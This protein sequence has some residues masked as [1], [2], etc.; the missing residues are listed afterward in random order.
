M[1][2]FRADTHVHVYN[3]Y[4]LTQFCNF[5]FENLNVS[6]HLTGILFLTLGS[7]EDRDWETIAARFR[8]L[9]FQVS[10]HS[11][12][13]SIFRHST[14]GA[15]LIVSGFQIITAEKIEVLSLAT[16]EI[17]PDGLPISETIER[18][19]KAGGKVVLPWSPGKWLGKRGKIVNSLLHAEPRGEILF[20]SLKGPLLKRSNVFAGSDPLPMKGE[21]S[22]VGKFGIEGELP[23]SFGF[24]L[25][26]CRGLL[27]SPHTSFGN[28]LPFY[29]AIWRYLRF[30]LGG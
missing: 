1:T 17:I 16:Q 11:G 28:P 10:N 21:E 12:C 13:L 30:C 4:D 9:S 3:A 25:A 15:L 7:R 23:K 14:P 2:R 24:T 22:L 27:D 19:Q 5:A 20:S 6:E 18:V 8:E 26:A 29:R